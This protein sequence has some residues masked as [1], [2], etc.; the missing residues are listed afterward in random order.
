MQKSESISKIAPALLAAQKNIGGAHKGAE[1]PFFKSAYASLGDV[2]EA[3]KEP[4]NEQGVSILQMVGHDEQGDYV[5]TIL[6]HESG[7]YISD[8]MRLVFG[9]QNDPQAQGS[10]ISY[11]RRYSL[12]SALFIP[13][14]DDDGEKAMD[15]VGKAK[16]QDSH[17]KKEES[18][19]E[20]L[21]REVNQSQESFAIDSVTSVREIKRGK[22]VYWIV[23]LENSKKELGTTDEELAKIAQS[24]ESEADQARFNY[25]LG[26][27][28]G[29]FKLDSITD[30][31]QLF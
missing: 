1:N 29:T 26:R 16:E 13:A 22:S 28:E 24:M 9:K 30:R 19:R 12:Q 5:E 4:L 8:R 2:M 21:A 10:A 25:S 17:F 7:E 31:K 18:D 27:T 20:R 6:L 3:C 23:V 11:S 15:R 14:V